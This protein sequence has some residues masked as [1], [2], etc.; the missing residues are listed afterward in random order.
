M[1]SSC[2]SIIAL[3]HE[4]CVPHISQAGIQQVAR[5][6]GSVLEEPISVG[7]ISRRLPTYLVQRYLLVTLV[8]NHV[9]EE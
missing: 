6:I 9:S 3:R 5:A 2:Q 4:S 8:V 1:L 7:H